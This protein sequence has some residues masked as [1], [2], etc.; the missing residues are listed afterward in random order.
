MRRFSKL[1]RTI[2]GSV[3]EQNYDGISDLVTNDGQDS[4]FGQQIDIMSKDDEKIAL[5][6]TSLAA[7]LLPECCLME[8][9]FDH[10]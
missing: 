2:C 4:D 3:M 7:E 10:R 1:G 5:S 6:S 9:G 8:P